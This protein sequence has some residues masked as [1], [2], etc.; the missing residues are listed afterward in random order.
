MKHSDVISLHAMIDAG[1]KAELEKKTKAM[2]MHRVGTV[3]VNTVD[4]VIISTFI[5]VV[6]LGKYSNYTLI[7]GVVSGTIALFFTP[8]TSVVGHLCAEGDKG[9]IKSYFDKFYCLNYVLGVVFFLAFYAVADSVVRLCFGS[10][11]E[12]SNSIVFVITLNQFT[13]YM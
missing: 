12:L 4:S 10:D 6:I 5:G 11:L 3:L 2:F 8:L 9:K 7:I 13:K 1:T